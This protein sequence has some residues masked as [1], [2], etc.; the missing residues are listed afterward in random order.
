MTP[1]A[2]HVRR[3]LAE[4]ADLATLLPTAL[5][6]RSPDD[7]Q[8]RT[9]PGSRPPVR[10]DVIQLLNNTLAQDVAAGRAEWM[11]PDR[12]GLLPYLW[13][14]CRD[15]EADALDAGLAPD[16]LPD[17]VAGCCSWLATW[18][19]FAQTLPQWDELVWGIERCWR[20]T[21]AA[22]RGVRDDDPPR[23]A[24]CNRCH[25]GTLTPS[26]DVWTC[27]DC[28]R[29]ISITA[30]SLPDA[31]RLTGIPLRTLQAW[32]ARSLLDRGVADPDDQRRTLYDLGTIRRV[33]A[34]AQL[35]SS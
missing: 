32:A 34:E 31:A 21:R 15:I 35:R 23:H 6:T 5:I 8:R 30:V 27:T 22:T 1:T 7:T 28:A 26:G 17:T 13:T 24:R 19:D 10:L 25:I 33:A 2:Q 29:I 16:D 14:W 11:D 3:W 20:N 4:L 9:A 18:L 12:A